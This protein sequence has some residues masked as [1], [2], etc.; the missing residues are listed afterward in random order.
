MG[1]NC[2]E[3]LN[4]YPPPSSAVLGIVNVRE[5]KRMFEAEKEICDLQGD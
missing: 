5:R 4:I 1:G 2:R 3:E